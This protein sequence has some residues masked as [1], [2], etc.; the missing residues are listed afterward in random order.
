[1]RPYTTAIDRQ[2]KIAIYGHQNGNTY[3]PGTV[4]DRLEIPTSNLG[5]LTTASSIK[6]C[7]N[8]CN[9]ER[10]PKVKLLAITAALA[11]ILQSGT[12]FRFS[13]VVAIACSHLYR[14]RRGR[15]CRI[16]R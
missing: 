1:M 14:A 6:V 12:N 9:N 4:T 16:C 8:K 11:R 10:H 13:V 2:L 3:I 5:F 15:K 7:P